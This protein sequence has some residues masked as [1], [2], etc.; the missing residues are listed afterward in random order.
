VVLLFV[1]GSSTT[2]K[3]GLMNFDLKVFWSNGWPMFILESITMRL[4]DDKI[5][6]SNNNIGNNIND[7]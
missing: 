1:Y 7:L 3:A 6:D 4:E 5:Y 2:S